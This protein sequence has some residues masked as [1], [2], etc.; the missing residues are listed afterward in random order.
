MSHA[1]SEPLADYEVTTPRPKYRLRFSLLALFF[2][3][4]I[5]CLALA[6]LVQ[7]KRV[8]ATAL[9]EVGRAQPALMGE[10]NFDER[11]L[12]IFKKTQLAKLRSYYVLSAA[13]RN[14]G[15]ASLVVF[16]NQ[17]DP[18]AWLQDHLETE[19]VGDSELLAI[20]LRGPESLRNDIVRIVDE[21][22][23][24]YEDEVVFADAQTQLTTR[25]LKA[26]CLKKLQE[27]LANTMQLLHDLKKEV[28]A[29]A[30][31]NVEIKLRQLELD[32]L[33]EMVQET[34]RSLERDDIEANAPPR[35]RKVQPAVPSLDN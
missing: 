8:V 26:A 21:V 3:V 25:D 19:F 10:E 11:E 14:P 30:S 33:T 17:R 5:V 24:A 28:G 35:I 31:D 20:R 13:V 22:A 12:E 18:A 15:I 7:P 29:G 23:K 9:F 34:S 2:F 27:E 6:W 4:T 1:A 16:A 32:T